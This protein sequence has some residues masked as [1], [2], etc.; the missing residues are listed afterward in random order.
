[1]AMF[2][3]LLLE[4]EPL[5][6]DMAWVWWA[7]AAGTPLALDVVWVWWMVAAGPQ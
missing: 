7:V 6:L 2:V 1:M 4:F 3:K 5:A